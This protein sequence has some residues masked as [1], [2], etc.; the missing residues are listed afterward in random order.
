MENT[1]EAIKANKKK[2]FLAR[3]IEHGFTE[4]Q[5]EFLWVEIEDKAFFRSNFGGLF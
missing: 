1:S 2:V 3:A 4:R 5:A